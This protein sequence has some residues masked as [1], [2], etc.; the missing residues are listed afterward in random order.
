MSGQAASALVSDDHLRHGVDLAFQHLTKSFGT[1]KVLDDVSFEMTAGQIVALLGQNGSGKS[2]LLKLLTGFHDPD[3]GTNA[4][5]V[6]GDTRLTLPLRDDHAAF[7]VAAVHQ[8][9]ALL[10]NAS[11][12]ENLLIDSIGDASLAPIRWSEVHRRARQIL[13]KVGTSDISTRTLVENLRPVQQAM[14]AI[15]RAMNGIEDGGLL[16]LDEVTAF[17]TQDSIDDL[18]T[19]VK[20]VAKRGVSVLFVSHR[21]EEIWRICDKA[22]VL[23]NGQLVADVDL[24]MTTSDDLISKIIGDRTDWL[25]PAKPPV[26][27]DPFLRVSGM[28]RGSAVVEFAARSGEIVG[29]T[30]L[31]GMGYERVVYAL[32]GE[33]RPSRGTMQLGTRQ[34]D[35]ARLTP[36]QAYGFNIRLLPSERLKN[37]AVA[38]ASVRENAV[39]PILP[40]FMRLGAL[41]R[42]REKNWAVQLLNSYNVVPSDPEALYGSLSGGNQ[43][44][45]LVAKWL[46]TGPQLLLLDEPTQGVDIGARRDIFS[47]IVGAAADGVTVLYATTEVRDLAELCHRVLVFRDGRIAGELTGTEVTEDAITRLCWSSSI[48]A[49]V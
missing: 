36:G 40:T 46:E 11:V 19:L 1:R 22:I 44:K 17:L 16:I 31:R 38:W 45:A 15:A 43:Q 3:N 20:E 18:F 39:L 41:D 49:K 26:A 37:G 30:G 34:I 14:V 32:Y 6:V 35:L 24:S 21:M 48:Q 13:G 2:T 12:A 29:L 5:V 33:D 7:R 23:R 10:Q 42:G 25:Y 27:G 8:D 9:L 47:R 28:T 4:A